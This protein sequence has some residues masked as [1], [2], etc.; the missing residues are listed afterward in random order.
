[1]IYNVTFGKKYYIKKYIKK[2]PEQ[3]KEKRDVK[4]PLLLSNY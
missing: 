3:K 4:I 2:I 1:M